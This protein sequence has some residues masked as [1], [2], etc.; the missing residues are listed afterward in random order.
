MA[1]PD[2]EKLRAMTNEIIEAITSD[3]FLSRMESMRE[4]TLQERLEMA[5]KLLSV[6]GLRK[7]GVDLP[8]G[9]RISSRYFEEDVGVFEFGNVRE[10][11]EQN[12]EVLATS[13]E[14]L[15]GVSLEVASMRTEDARL[16]CVL[17]TGNVVMGTCGGAGAASIC[18]CG[19]SC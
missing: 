17:S 9:M 12:A 8:E 11:D 16:L 7:A 4:A 2:A 3:E 1:R 10:F 14:K 18:A 15:A 5:Q 6:E 19:G 13:S